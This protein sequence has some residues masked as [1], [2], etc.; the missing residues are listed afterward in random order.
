MRM[1][2]F[3]S[4]IAVFVLSGSWSLTKSRDDFSLIWNPTVGM[5]ATSRFD[6]VLFS[7]DWIVRE[8]FEDDWDFDQFHF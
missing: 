3:I 5:A 4:V 1:K 2:F 7:G 8:G 6:A